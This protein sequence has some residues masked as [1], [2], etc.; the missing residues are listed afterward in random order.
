MLEVIKRFKSADKS[1]WHHRMSAK[2]CSI[3]PQSIFTGVNS[4]SIRL[5]M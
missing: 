2:V 3:H 1:N 5:P 4:D